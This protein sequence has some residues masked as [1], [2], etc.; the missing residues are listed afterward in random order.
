MRSRPPAAA[1]DE[2]MPWLDDLRSRDASPATGWRSEASPIGA[3][4]R[5][6]L[7]T[8][9]PFTETKEAMEGD[10]IEAS[11]LT[12]DSVSPPSIPLPRRAGQVRPFWGT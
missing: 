11:D 1:E 12:S 10:I 9:G 4:L 5:R 3:V 2:D 6:E 8:D 7:V